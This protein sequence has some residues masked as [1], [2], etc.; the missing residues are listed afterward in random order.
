MVIIN[1]LIIRQLLQVIYAQP[2]LQ[3]A[4]QDYCITYYRIV[5]FHFIWVLNIMLAALDF[6]SKN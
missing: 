1:L 6:I 2:L 5:H 4:I 3:N